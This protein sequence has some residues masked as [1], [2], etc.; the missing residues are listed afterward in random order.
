MILLLA[1]TAEGRD[2][3]QRLGQA[4]ADVT[5]SLA[6]AVR[7]PRGLPV[8]ARIGG[9]GGAAGFAAYLRDHHIRAVVDA[10]HPFAARITDRSARICAEMDVP[11]LRL[12]RPAWQPEAGDHWTFI[13][14]EAEAANH[15]PTGATVFLATGRQ[16]LER[17]ANLTGRHLICR[18]IDPPDGP[19]PFA[20]GEFLVGRPP[21]SVSDEMALFKRLKVDVLVVKNA[22][23]T[24]SR[25]K[26]AAARA[27]GL[28]V[29]MVK[30]P[31]AVAAP[32]VATV[33]QAM[34]W[35]TRKGLL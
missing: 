6:G 18:Q 9:F 10:T 11:Y 15:V 2:L 25:S 35:L 22:G 19:F 32:T 20:N 26:L 31:P 13:A 28:P 24:P 17:F 23:G 27:L 3:A 33:D 14:D 16:T 12:E 29:L 4:G 1:G 8:P 5:A 30:R 34:D 7:H 21:F